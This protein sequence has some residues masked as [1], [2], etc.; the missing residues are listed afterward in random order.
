ME[1][2]IG[3]NTDCTIIVSR[4]LVHDEEMDAHEGYNEYIGY[5]HVIDEIRL[6]YAYKLVLLLFVR[7]WYRGC[8]LLVVREARRMP[9]LC[10]MGELRHDRFVCRELGE[11]HM[12][13]CAEAEEYR[14]QPKEDERRPLLGVGI[15]ECFRRGGT[16]NGG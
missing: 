2:V 5:R 12:C 11:P 14:G 16:V 9:M 8:F 1:T 7:R 15:G 13:A 6:C 4:D 10:C 3:G